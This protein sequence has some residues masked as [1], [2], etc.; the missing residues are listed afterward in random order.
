[1]KWQVL[2]FWN[3]LKIISEINA[4]TEHTEI[5]ETDKSLV[6]QI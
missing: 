6:G 2:E 4:L 3:W 5:T 1:M